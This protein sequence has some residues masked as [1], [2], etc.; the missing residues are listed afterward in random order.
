[1]TPL[2]RRS[3]RMNADPNVITATRPSTD[4]GRTFYRRSGLDEFGGLFRARAF[5]HDGHQRAGH[6][7]GI[8]VLENV[9]AINNAGSALLGQL[10]GVFQ[11][12]FVGRFAAAADEHG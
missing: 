6:A 1:M 2:Y 9:A 3:T 8:A 12:F 11:N 4:Q 5:M 10:F 7:G